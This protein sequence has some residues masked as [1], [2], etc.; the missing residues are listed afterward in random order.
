MKIFQLKTTTKSNKNNKQRTNKELHT[1][2]I[3][4]VTRIEIAHVIVRW[5]TNG[6]LVGGGVAPYGVELFA[7]DLVKDGFVCTVRVMK[8]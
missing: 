2:D 7:H 8:F 5:Y 3:S 4:T 6:A 1:I